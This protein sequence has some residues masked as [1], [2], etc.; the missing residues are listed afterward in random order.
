MKREGFTLVEIILVILLLSLALG[1]VAP[2]ISGGSLR[3]KERGFVV[4]LVEAISKAREKVIL[5]GKPDVFFIDPRERTF[6]I[7]QKI[8]GDIPKNV[9]LYAEGMEAPEDGRYVIKFFPDGTCQ[10][11]RL[12]VTFDKTRQ[13][14]ISI[15]PVLGSISWEEKT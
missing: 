14:I 13:Y 5:S 3:M 9:D 6:G 2:R 12:D 8:H 7:G 10:A 1:M 11:V 15:D 4:A